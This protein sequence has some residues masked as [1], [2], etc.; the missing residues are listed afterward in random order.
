MSWILAG[1]GAVIG[2]YYFGLIMVVAL[3]YCFPTAEDILLD[4]R[5]KWVKSLPPADREAFLRHEKRKK[6][7]I[8]AYQM[9]RLPVVIREWF[10]LDRPEHVYWDVNVDSITRCNMDLTSWQDVVLAPDC[11]EHF[12]GDGFSFRKDSMTMN[13]KPVGWVMDASKE[14]WLNVKV[15]AANQWDHRV[16][17]GLEDVHNYKGRNEHIDKALQKANLYVPPPKAPAIP[18]WMALSRVM[19]LADQLY[20]R[21]FKLEEFN[22]ER[23]KFGQPPLPALK[24]RMIGGGVMEVFDPADDDKVVRTIQPWEQ[25]EPEGACGG[26]SLYEFMMQQQEEEESRSGR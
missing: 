11:P 5:N 24:R 2:L 8:K 17:L 10:R 9:C 18:R 21:E 1:I 15:A 6:A 13:G 4:R 14:V 26:H 7:Y 19:Y 3:S 22:A 12:E 23:A 16:A 20:I 25:F